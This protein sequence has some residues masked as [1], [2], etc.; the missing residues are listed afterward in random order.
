MLTIYICLDGSTP[1]VR[2]WCSVPRIGEV[3]SLPEL[4]G[5][6]DPLRVFDV[7]WEGFDEPSVSVYVHHAKIEHSMCNGHPRSS[8][9][10]SKLRENN[11]SMAE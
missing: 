6:L 8:R 7:I 5:N 4:G 11:N 10:D 3:I 1:V 2:R 9:F